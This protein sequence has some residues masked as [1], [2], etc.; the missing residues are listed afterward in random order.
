MLKEGSNPH[1][2]AERRHHRDAVKNMLYTPRV[3]FTAARNGEVLA[4]PVKRGKVG[5]EPAI[6]FTGHLFWVEAMAHDGLHGRLFTGSADNVVRVWNDRTAE[7]LFV[8]SGHRSDVSC[9]ALASNGQE[10]YSGSR[11]STV[12]RWDC[13]TGE[14]IEEY[15]GHG[16]WIEAIAVEGPVLFTVSHDKTGRIWNTDTAQ[17]LHILAAHS[18]FVDR[19]LVDRAHKVLFTMS[20]DQTM[21]AWDY[22]SGQLLQ[23]TKNLGTTTCAKMIARDLFVGTTA[24]IIKRYDGAAPFDFK[25]QYRGIEGDVLCFGVMGEFLYA[26]GGD[27]SVRVFLTK[28]AELVDTW[29]HHIG[30]VNDMCFGA[31]KFLIT[32]GDDRRLG[33]W[34]VKTRKEVPRELLNGEIADGADRDIVKKGRKREERHTLAPQKAAV[35][36]M[37]NDDDAEDMSISARSMTP[38]N[39]GGIMINTTGIPDGLHELT[40]LGG[41]ELVA[42]DPED[43]LGSDFDAMIEAADDTHA[44]FTSSASASASASRQ[45]T[46]SPQPPRLFASPAGSDTRQ[47][48]NASESGKSPLLP[49]L[50]RKG[51]KLEVEGKRPLS[52]LPHMGQDRPVSANMQRMQEKH[53]RA[54]RLESQA[55]KRQ[56][57]RMADMAVLQRSNQDLP[58]NIPKK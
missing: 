1:F 47:M 6:V 58:I 38:P 12:R 39:H 52:A 55:K 46:A 48:G 56:N 14:Y 7:C 26:G 36:D 11:D 30:A 41:R 53:A 32:A 15:K 10:L 25:M 29:R 19:L 13:I 24:G 31:D 5:K 23:Q 9:V 45:A 17:T 22:S 40:Q 34:K 44:D 3:L 50:G 18:S 21:I 27:G 16:S 4:W 42:D 20:G 43:L 28:T 2:Y 54:E 35:L 49:T 57:R 33:M 37:D 8:L 51:G